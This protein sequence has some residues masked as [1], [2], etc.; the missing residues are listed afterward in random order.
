MVQ[1]DFTI[2]VWLK[3]VSSRVGQYFYHGTSI[4]FADVSATGSM[5]FSLAVLNSKFVMNIGWPDVEITSATTVT[6]GDW[7]HVAGTRT[8]AT[9]DFQIFVNGQLEASGVNHTGA[10]DATPIISVGCW[11]SAD[12]ALDGLL[13]E[14][15]IWETVRTPA[16]IDAGMHLALTGN[17]PGLV[18]YY[19][20][21]DMGG[22][23]LLDSSSQGN[24][25]TVAGTILPVSSNAPGCNGSGGAP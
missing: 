23:Q 17:E 3:T 24:H 2:E 18:G 21:D 20:F 4:T 8:R 19:R 1:D 5:D 15:K 11:A 16:E 22:S 9:G 25:G 12:A 10:L 7:V 6:T 14:L 13:D